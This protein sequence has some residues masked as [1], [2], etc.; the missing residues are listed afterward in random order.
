MELLRTSHRDQL[1]KIFTTN[2][3]SNIYEKYLGTYIYALNI[4]NFWDNA[5]NDIFVLGDLIELVILSRVPFQAMLK[6]G[7]SLS[8]VTVSNVN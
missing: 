7:K 3:L 1:P 2:L 6:A 4:L 8:D 5:F